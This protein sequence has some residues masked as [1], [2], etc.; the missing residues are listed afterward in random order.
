VPAEPGTGAPDP[1][2]GKGLITRSGE[3]IAV[4]MTDFGIFKET[5]RADVPFAYAFDER[6][7]AA[8]DTLLAHGVVVER[9]NRDMELDV[10][11]FVISDVQRAE[12]PFQQHHEITLS[13]K[14]KRGKD[15]LPVNTHIVRMN[16]PLARL[17]FYLLDPRSDDGLINWNYF[18]DLFEEVAPVRRIV[19]PAGL[20]AT[21]ITAG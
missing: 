16:Q 14:W 19:K 13:G 18:D 12:E 5:E 3:I 8:V 20:D 7:T 17:A 2:T 11:R 1:E 9:L 10:E 15:V 21:V 6:A 4:R